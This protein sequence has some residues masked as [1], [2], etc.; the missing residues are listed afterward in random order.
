MANTSAIQQQAAHT[1]YQLSS[2]CCSKLLESY[3]EVY[4]LTNKFGELLEKNSGKGTVS[5]KKDKKGQSKRR[6]TEN[7]RGDRKGSLHQQGQIVRIGY[8]FK[9]AVHELRSCGFYY[10]PLPLLPSALDVLFFF[11][12]DFHLVTVSSYL[13]IVILSVCLSACLPLSVCLSPLSVCMHKSFLLSAGSTMTSP[14]RTG[15][16]SWAVKFCPSTP[17]KQAVINPDQL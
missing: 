9:V 4:I 13:L 5:R 2:P 1:G 8:C 6:Q 16:Q 10:P 12:S 3:K 14:L 7:Q 17:G 11:F 15:W